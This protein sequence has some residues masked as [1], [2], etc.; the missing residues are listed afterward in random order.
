VVLSSVVG[1][2]EI[3]YSSVLKGGYMPAFVEEASDRPLLSLNPCMP[4]P[5]IWHRRLRAGDDGTQG[6]AV[7]TSLSS[8]GLRDLMLASLESQCAHCLVLCGFVVQVVT[9]G[10]GDGAIRIDTTATKLKLPLGR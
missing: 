7:V 10:E 5:A 4:H 6:R 2:W 3:V 9:V 1:R 8:R